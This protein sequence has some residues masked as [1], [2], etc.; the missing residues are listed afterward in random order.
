M[1]TTRPRQLVAHLGYV[2]R[3]LGLVWAAASGW[4]LAWCALLVVQGLL[5]VL[6][7]Y[8][9]R[10]LVDGVVAAVGAEPR[11]TP[12]IMLVAGLLIAGLVL[13]EVLQSVLEW[14][15]AAQAELTRDHISALVHDRS[16]TVDLAFYESSD[17][18][19]HLH[20]ARDESGSRPLALLESLGSLLQ[21]SITLAAMAAVLLPY[22]L[23]LPLALLGSTLPALLVA[24]RFDWRYHGWWQRS[25]VTR[26]RA[27][28]YDWMLST[29]ESAAEVRL[30]GLGG[31]FRQAYQTLRRR[32]RSERL[33][34]I[35]RQILARMGA[36]A[37]GVLIGG[38]ALAWMVWRAMHGL[39]TLGDLALLYQA[40]HRGQALMR[41]LLSDVGQI[42]SNSLFLAHLFAFLDLKPQI[43]DPPVPAAPLQTLR[44][45]IEFRDVTFRYPGSERA[46]LCDFSLSVPA[47]QIVAI[48]GENGAGKSTLTKL[49]CRFY[50]PEA[51]RITF[52]DTDLRQFSVAGLRRMLAVLFQMPVPYHAT[53]TENIALGDV[54]QP[55]DMAAIVG[56]ARSAGADEVIRRLPQ[57]YDTLLG[58]WFAEG[59]ELSGGE[60]QRLALAR[61]FLRSS[62]VIVLDEPTSFMDSWAEA[63]WF[64]RLRALAA[65]RTALLIT[66]R[67]T[68]AMRADMIHVMHEGRIVE[69]GS[70]A[71][72]L[73][74]GGR[75]AQSWQAQLTASRDDELETHNE[76][77]VLRSVVR[78]V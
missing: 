65:G 3:A 44:R 58:K 11:I 31:H 25:T 8:L 77:S 10:H 14:V 23:W 42:Y 5:P 51:G 1:Q 32:L 39:V 47:G 70:H 9:T 15:R 26:R 48:V 35:E 63:E 66:H 4:T 22:A 7:V 54:V 16:A 36:G 56:A 30:F 43:V 68:I 2:P 21:N 62:P 71:A 27:D 24:L 64:E 72:L 55:P 60:W 59:T 19:D 53:A 74:L 46:A 20:R 18:H 6:T 73:A 28:Y 61:A 29:T 41:A 50:D 76:F 13:S 69:S 49:L 33:Q 67:F 12:A 75:Y 57:G 40:F 45:G 78:Y 37:A 34:L 38:A 52:D 17:Y